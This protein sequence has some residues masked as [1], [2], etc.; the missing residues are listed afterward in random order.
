MLRNR[1]PASFSRKRIKK[2]LAPLLV[3]Q[4]L[5][6]PLALNAQLERFELPDMG[7]SAGALITPQQ[8]KELGEAFFRSL[9]AQVEV[10]HDSDVQ[11]YIE[12]LGQ[13][14]VARSD[15]PAGAFHFFVVNEKTIN[16]FAGPGGYIGVHSG[17][18][19]TTESESELASVLAHEIAHVTQRHLYRAFEAAGQLSLPTAAATLA[20]I[21]L[22]T[23]S[24]ALGQ[25]AL[26]AAQAANAQFQINFTRDN[27]KEADRVGM[28]ILSASGYDPRSMP[29]FFERLQQS[30]RYHGAQIPEFLRTHP[31]TASRIADTRDRAEQYPYRQYPDSQDY[32]LIKT[33]LQVLTQDDDKDLLAALRAREQRGVAEQRASARYGI[34]LIAMKQQRFAEAAK[35][36]SELRGAFP[37]QV[38]YATALAR[39]QVEQSQYPEAIALLKDLQTR[40]PER[41]G[42]KLEYVTTLLKAGQAENARDFLQSLNARLQ[43]TPLFYKLMAQTYGDLGQ[44]AESHRYMA[45]YYYVTG[46]TREA[47][48]QI[49]LAQQI[50]D[51]NLYLGAILDERLRFFLSEALERKRSR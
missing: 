36:F 37:E 21:L 7:D 30:S 47:I 22:G 25:A 10:I 50:K 2:L 44:R 26:M 29:L 12:T 14:L 48:I 19:I 45:E 18:I 3:A 35:I 49:R 13:R 34:G 16:A 8:E 41:D 28:Q 46:Q 1:V 23:Q 31:V 38:Q 42:L 4:L 24:P 51:N 6:W 27:E 5:A 11:T 43:R 17:L 15:T 9:H 40:F 20:A 33:K 39:T 32:L